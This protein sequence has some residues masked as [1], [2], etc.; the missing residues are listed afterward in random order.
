[1]YFFGELPASSLNLSS[2]VLWNI[3]VSFS[4]KKIFNWHELSGL[5]YFRK[6]AGFDQCLPTREVEAQVRNNWKVL[7]QCYSTT[8]QKQKPK[9][10]FGLSV[11]YL[12]LKSSVFLTIT[13]G[14]EN[15]FHERWIRL[16]K[17]THARIG[18]R[19]LKDYINVILICV[20]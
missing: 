12:L 2:E 10:I 11:I 7:R 6:W 9:Q 3:F 1:M 20:S 17:Y 4:R 13:H 19:K 18:I 16:F 14:P 5:D 15:G 8:P